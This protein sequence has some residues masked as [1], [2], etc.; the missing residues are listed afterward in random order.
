MIEDPIIEKK[1]KIRSDDSI[2]MPYC[3]YDTKAMV[4]VLFCVFYCSLRRVLKTTNVFGCVG[5]RHSRGV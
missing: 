1:G 2:K 5:Q 3:S 4:T